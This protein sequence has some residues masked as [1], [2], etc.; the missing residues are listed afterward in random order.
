MQFSMDGESR[1]TMVV[2]E[3]KDSK[4]DGIT[5]AIKA[6]M[7]VDPPIGKLLIGDTVHVRMGRSSAAKLWTAVFKGI[8]P[9]HAEPEASSKNR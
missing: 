1:D 5:Q 6:R 9:E 7:I 8:E 2:V 4:Y 3:W